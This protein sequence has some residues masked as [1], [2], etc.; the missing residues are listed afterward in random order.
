MSTPAA[1]E[2]R[3]VDIHA[4]VVLGEAFGHAGP[5]GPE[6]G[7][8]QG[9][10]F[11]RVGNYKMKPMDYRGSIFMDVDKRIRAMDRAGIDLQMLSPNPLTFFGGIEAKHATPFCRATNDAMAELVAA[12]PDRLLGSAAMPLQDPDAAC[13]EL[14]RSVVELGLV[15]AYAGTDYGF[16]LDDARLDDFYRTLVSLDV[17][18]FLHPATNDGAEAAPDERLH[19]F[20]LDLIVGYTYEETLAVAA[21]LLGGVFDRHPAVD[22]CISHGGGAIAF[23]V[24]RFDSMAR[25]RRQEEGFGKALRKLWFDS[26]MEAGPSRQLLVDLVG[27]DRLVYGTNFGGWDTPPH[28]D[29]FD[30]SLTPNVERLLRLSA[31]S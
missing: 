24:E 8:D 3:V 13:L 10:P 11:F 26:H 12:H 15:G 4:H 1:S 22:I 28:T 29:D 27:I 31:R 6:H 21:L 14:E 2:K 19:R 18:L 23:L 17:P 7:D 16:T 5:Y 25:F 9:T 30:A 20:G